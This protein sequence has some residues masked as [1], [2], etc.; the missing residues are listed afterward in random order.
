MEE[1]EGPVVYRVRYSVP[2]EGMPEGTYV[3]ERAFA[4]GSRA[5]LLCEDF[6]GRV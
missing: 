3:E 6:R 2:M 4:E 1:E 5:C